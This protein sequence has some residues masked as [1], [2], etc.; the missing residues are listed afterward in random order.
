MATSRMS[1]VEVF[2][3]LGVS[4]DVDFLRESVRVL[5]QCVMDLEATMRAGA[6]RYE[7]TEGRQTSRNGS[8]PSQWKTRVGKIELRIPKLR[9]GSYYPSFLGRN[10]RRL[11]EKAL[12]SVVQE[13]YVHGVSTRKVDDLLRSLGLDGISKSEV[14]RICM[15]LDE[16]VERFRHRPL[17]GDYPYVWFDATFVKVREHGRVLSMAVVVAIGVRSTGDREVLGVDLGPAEEGAFWL[18]FLRSLVARGL[19]GVQL[20]ISDAHEGLKGALA[21]VLGGVTWQ[22]CRVHFMR[23]ALSQVPKTV[24]PVVA[25]TIRTIFAQPD[26]SSAQEQLRRVADGM[27]TKFPRVSQRLEE[28]EADILAYLGFPEEHR[29]QLHSTNPLERLNKEIKRRTDVVGIFPNRAAAIR[30]VGA[31]LAEQSDE[32]ATGRRYFSQESMAKLLSPEALTAE[33]GYLAAD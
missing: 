7:R 27:R 25:A 30:L 12:L 8:R 6:E 18:S 17:E 19:G 26:Q 31:I 15:E 16:G 5:A 1:L 3:K 28:A 33:L 2:H 20:V 13:A 9:K 24:Q 32:W 23:N 21:A 29:R 22:R 11:T 4:N 10:Q 14:S